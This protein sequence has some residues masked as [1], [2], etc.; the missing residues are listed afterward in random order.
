MKTKPK[1]RLLLLALLS[2]AGFAH[3][4]GT[5]ISYQGRLNHAGA[6]ATGLHDF[7]FNM[8]D[9]EA[10][11][12][13][14]ATTVVLAAVPVTNGLFNV[15]LNFGPN[16]FTGPA[17]WLEI[18][19]RTNGSVA[20]Y[21]ILTPRQ[22][23]TPSPYAIFAGKAG[24]V[25][26]GTVTANQLNTGGLAPAPGQFLSYNGGNLLWSDPAVVTGNVWS[27]SGANAYYNAGKVGI[28]TTI[29]GNKLTVHT[30]TLEYGIDH[31]YED[32][33]SSLAGS[34]EGLVENSRR[35][36]VR[37]LFRRA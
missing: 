19:L 30:P 13:A 5:A 29:P 26:N 28:G 11:G 17:R 36:A 22:A 18:G 3:G 25:A 31:D 12:T 32:P 8:F 23:L 6:P 10:G 21:S 4:Q 20:A 35:N 34:W 27:R 9:V 15:S 7:T 14:L 37:S 33:K 1:L 16:I 2:L 24:G